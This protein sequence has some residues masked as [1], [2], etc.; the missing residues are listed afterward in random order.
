MGHD[1]TVTVQVRAGAEDSVPGE[2]MAGA[3]ATGRGNPGVR[4]GAVG[5]RPPWAVDP[6]GPGPYWEEAP[7][8]SPQEEMGDLK[9][10]EASLR[11]EL[12][13]IQKRLAELEKEASGQ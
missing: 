13:A 8:A 11:G 10:Q 4:A 1:G 7:Y 3:G 9:E 2:V 5:A 12:E 6:Y